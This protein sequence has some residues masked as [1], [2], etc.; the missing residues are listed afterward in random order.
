MKKTIPEIFSRY[1]S[2][3][4]AYSGGVDSAVLMESAHRHYGG[5]AFAVIADSAS[6]PRSEFESAQ[7][8][9][10]E[11]GWNLSVVQ[12]KEFEDHRYLENP[13]NRCYFCKSAL[14]EKM[15][16]F[17]VD[18]QL[19]ALAYGE[20]LD[21]ESEIRWGRQAAEEFEVIAPLREAGYTKLM[22]RA[23]ARE[24]GM[25]VA[26]KVASPCLS[27]RIQTG[28]SIQKG[29]LERVDQGE[30]FLRDL[31]FKIFRI[32]FDGIRARVFVAKNELPELLKRDIQERVITFLMGIGFKEAV[33]SEIPYQG[34]SLR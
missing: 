14:F 21:D 6:L 19:D 7:M 18:H 28:I 12:T 1:Q 31:G 33:I 25:E 30:S 22:V 9:A 3:A 24:W 15:N 8:L 29:D 32:R 2:I 4:I 27:S 16:Q 10:M 5:N 34:A 20:N 13:V 26:E 17:A 11:R 23:L